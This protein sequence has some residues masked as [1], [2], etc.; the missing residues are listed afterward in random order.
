MADNRNLIVDRIL[1]KRDEDEPEKSF[2][3]ER[4]HTAQA[5]S[6]HLDY[7]NGLSKEG[8]AWSHFGRY[9]WRNHGSH[10]SLKIIFG[11]LCGVE[12]TGHNFEP[13][14]T[15][16]RNGQLNGIKEM[17]S[18]QAKLGQAEGVD[19]PIITGIKAYPDFDALFEA[20]KEEGTEQDHDATHAGRV[21]GRGAKGDHQP[22]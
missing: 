10:E 3:K 8:V 21:R 14:L 16:I 18:G 13:L 1:K 15:D 4:Q 11:G 12:I 2:T 22:G 9:Q 20:L 6:L 5:F 17:L 19:D 7:R